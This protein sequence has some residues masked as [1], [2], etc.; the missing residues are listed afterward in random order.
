MAGQ[1]AEQSGPEENKAFGESNEISRPIGYRAVVF[2]KA[3]DDRPGIRA[4]GSFGN[5]HLCIQNLFVK[6]I[7]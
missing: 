1:G 5:S 6:I 3:V 7:Q 4:G 2:M